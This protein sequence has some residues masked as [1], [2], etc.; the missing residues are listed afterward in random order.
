MQEHDEDKMKL[1][2]VLNALASDPFEQVSEPRADIQEALK[3]QAA[4]TPDQVIQEREALISTLEAA[5]AELCCSLCF[6]H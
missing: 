2:F 3:W 4:R 1:N 6:S 5:G